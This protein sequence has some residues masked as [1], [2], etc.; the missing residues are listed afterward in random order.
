MLSSVANLKAHVGIPSSDTSKDVLLG[1]ILRGASKYIANQCNRSFELLERTEF[2]DGSGGDQ[3]F[4][5]NFPVT[6][7]AEVKINDS[8]LTLNDEG[9]IIEN[10]SVFRRNGWPQGRKNISVTYSAGYI[11]YTDEESGETPNVPEDLEL[12]TIR[13]AAR[14]YE[15]RTAEGVGSVSPGGFTAQF[16]AA[17]DSD[18]IEVINYYRKFHI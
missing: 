7:I 17:I 1:T 10:S 12:I 11:T 15:R 2:Y 5:N 6:E 3:L 14:V 4:L 13:I 18:I 8:V 16:A 9:L